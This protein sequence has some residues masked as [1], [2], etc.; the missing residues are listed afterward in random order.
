M[1]LLRPGL[2]RRPPWSARALN[3]AERRQSLR[4]DREFREHAGLEVTGDVADEEIGA[5]LCQIHRSRLRLAGIDV[6]AVADE[7]DA[8]SVLD[9]V[10]VLVDRVLGRREVA[11]EDQ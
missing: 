6:V 10:A 3:R 7:V 2:R 9:D 5:G 4:R 8:R 1:V 11:L